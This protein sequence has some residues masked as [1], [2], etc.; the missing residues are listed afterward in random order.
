MSCSYSNAKLDKVEIDLIL[1]IGVSAG[2]APGDLRRVVTRPKSVSFTPP[3]SYAERIDQLYDMTLVIMI[4]GE[5]HEN[6]LEVCKG[7]AIALGLKSSVVD[8]MITNIIR[9]IETEEQSRVAEGNI[10]RSSY[11]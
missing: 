2:I 1:D 6:E 10:L 4:D 3:E 9:Q 7:F 8:K 5:I 11:N